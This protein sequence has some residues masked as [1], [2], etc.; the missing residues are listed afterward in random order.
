MRRFSQNN[1][2]MFK[3]NFKFVHRLVE[4]I[5]SRGE[6]TCMLNIDL[7]QLYWETAARFLMLWGSRSYLQE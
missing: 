7:V 6:E 2:L 4:G 5:Y 3:M 1:Q